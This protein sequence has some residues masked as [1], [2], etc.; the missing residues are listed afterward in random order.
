MHSHACTAMHMHW[1][2]GGREG[3]GDEA[4]RSSNVWPQPT[5]AVSVIIYYMACITPAKAIGALCRRKQNF[6]CS[7]NCR[8][9][10]RWNRQLCCVCVRACA[11]ALAQHEWKRVRVLVCLCM[12]T[13]TCTTTHQAMPGAVN[14]VPKRCTPARPLCGAF[15]SADGVC[16]AG[17]IC[18]GK[19]IAF[20]IS[21][22]PSNCID[23]ISKKYHI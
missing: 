6:R 16:N 21:V 2:T 22:L 7:V 18:T 19:I 11:R 12:R 8:R 15:S 1:M 5:C 4:T 23:F 10:P 9:P 17:F 14:C 13:C 3:G 20:T